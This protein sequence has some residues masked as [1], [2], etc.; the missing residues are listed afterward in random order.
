MKSADKC[1]ADLDQQDTTQTQATNSNGSS[2]SY[3]LNSTEITSFAFAQAGV[4][5]SAKGKNFQPP[6]F[7]VHH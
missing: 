3:G 6:I 2:P 4:N 7:S 1:P 5:V